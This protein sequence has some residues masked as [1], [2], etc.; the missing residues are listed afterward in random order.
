MADKNCI[1][2]S[3]SML[4]VV[5]CGQVVAFSALAQGGPQTCEAYMTRES[6]LGGEGYYGVNLSYFCAWTDETCQQGGITAKS[7]QL[8]LRNVG[9]KNVDPTGKFDSETI[10]ALQQFQ[11]QNGLYLSGEPDKATIDALKSPAEAPRG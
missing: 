9:F 2:V 1:Q 8:L 7:L 4:L 10:R 3:I 5:M 6:C 11:E